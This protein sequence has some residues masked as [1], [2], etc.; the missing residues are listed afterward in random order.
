MFDKKA[1][2]KRWQQEHRDKVVENSRKWREKN[3]DKV[4]ASIKKWRVNNIDKVRELDKKNH[5]KFIE[6]HDW[7][8]YCAERRK[9][10]VQRLR[11]QGVK[12]PW[13]VI[14]GKEAKYD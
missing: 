1:Y 7:V 10:R 5:K 9:A 4:R 11:E 14:K 12:N 8:Q 6:N 3:P 13:A 2:M